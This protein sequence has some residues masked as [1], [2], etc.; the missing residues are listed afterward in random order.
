[1]IWND[2]MLIIFFL[3]LSL[4]LPLP[5][6]FSLSHI[7]HLL[8]LPISL[9]LSSFSLLLPPLSCP[10]L[11]PSHLL[12]V[13]VCVCV[14][15]CA[16]ARACLSL[17]HTHTHTH[18]AMSN[19]PTNSQRGNDNEYATRKGEYSDLLPDLFSHVYI[20]PIFC[21]GHWNPFFKL[22]TCLTSCLDFTW[23]FDMNF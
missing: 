20:V 1:M 12:C 8:L 13:C 3:S 7:L 18:S 22:F 11:P 23:W 17:S 16:R 14:C 9:L 5:F 2:L 19:L 4:P 15:V 21:N 6:P 10:F